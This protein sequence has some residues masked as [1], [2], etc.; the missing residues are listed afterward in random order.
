MVVSSL[1]MDR[2]PFRSKGHDEVIS[3]PE[4]PYLSMNGAFEYLANCT[5]PNFAFVA[6]LL[7]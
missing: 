5:K 3:G 2:H 6:E 1:V 4:V 7:A